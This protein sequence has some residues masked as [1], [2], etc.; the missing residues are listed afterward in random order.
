VTRLQLKGKQGY[1]TVWSQ[2]EEQAMYAP[3]G[4]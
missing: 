3:S 2:A 4:K 1:Q